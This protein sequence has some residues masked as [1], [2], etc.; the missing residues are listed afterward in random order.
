MLEVRR[1]FLIKAYNGYAAVGHGG[2]YFDPDVSH[3][4]V[5][6]SEQSATD[7]VRKFMTHP[8]SPAYLYQMYVV[9][10]QVNYET[11]NPILVPDVPNVD[12]N[13]GEG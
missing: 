12:F 9:P 11:W 1:G 7:M 10:I 5:Y 6:P 2:L 4:A 3:A 13:T 8:D